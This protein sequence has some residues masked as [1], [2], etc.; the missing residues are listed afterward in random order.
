VGEDIDVLLK[1]PGRDVMRVPGR[2]IDRQPRELGGI[3]FAIAYRSPTPELSEAIAGLLSS[4]S[5]S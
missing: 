5:G 4:E 1:L 3:G 2:V